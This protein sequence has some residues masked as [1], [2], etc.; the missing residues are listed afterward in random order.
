MI[1]E[2]TLQCEGG[3]KKGA[4][5]NASS[6]LAWLNARVKRQQLEP[7]NKAMPS[8]QS[9]EGQAH[10]AQAVAG[11]SRRQRHVQEQ[12]VTLKT[13]NVWVL[14]KQVLLCIDKGIIVQSIK[15]RLQTRPMLQPVA[16]VEGNS[17][18]LTY[19]FPLCLLQSPAWGKSQV[20]GSSLG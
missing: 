4:R 13:G 2:R 1:H 15:G 17:M 14:C 18:L 5:L 10:V 8:S 9:S 3:D 20:Q 19:S 7:Q 16:N 12:A 6:P 11:R